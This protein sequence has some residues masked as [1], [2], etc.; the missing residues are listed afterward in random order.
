MF[1][2]GFWELVLI[3][4][5]ALL[6]VGPERLPSLLRTAGLWIG[7]L[8]RTVSGL[9]AQLEREFE[10]EEIRKLGQSVDPRSLKQTIE[11]EMTPRAPEPASA[12][13]TDPVEPETPAN[14]A[15]DPNT[16]PP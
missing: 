6:V 13:A 4:V 15:Q 10:L 7:R 8:R 5:I 12:N 9:Q 14:P 16:P 2:V 3:S 1:E 11:D